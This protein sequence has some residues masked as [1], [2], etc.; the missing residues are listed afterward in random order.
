MFD[1]HK[2][3]FFYDFSI[4]NFTQLVWW[5]EAFVDDLKKL[6][7]NIGFHGWTE[8]WVVPHYVSISILIILLD[9]GVGLY[10]NL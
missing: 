4:K 1:I 5:W 9:L 6:F 10:F 2:E 3:L 8:T 7:S